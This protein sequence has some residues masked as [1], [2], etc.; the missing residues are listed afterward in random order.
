VL[1]VLVIL[2]CIAFL[3]ALFW[4]SENDAGTTGLVA[5]VL[6]QLV[7]WLFIGAAV[8]ILILIGVYAISIR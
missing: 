7:K 5:Y 1:A 2:A 4:L 6:L 3:L 8:V